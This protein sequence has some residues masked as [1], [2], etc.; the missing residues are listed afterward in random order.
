MDLQ[1]DIPLNKFRKFWLSLG[2]WASIKPT[3]QSLWKDS[4]STVLVTMQLV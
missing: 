1:M 3:A 4:E 2:S